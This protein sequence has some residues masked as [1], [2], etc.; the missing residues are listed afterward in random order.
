MSIIRVLAVC[1][2]VACGLGACTQDPLEP[3]TERAG[4]LATDEEVRPLAASAVVVPTAE[5]HQAALSGNPETMADAAAALV[6]CPAPT[7]CPGYSN[8]SAWSAYADCNATCGF[9]LCDPLGPATNSIIRDHTLT[10]RAKSYRICTNSMGQSC[11][12][13]KVATASTCGC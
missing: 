10:E 11:T 5:L 2:I 8:C 13:W 7:T 9:P 3:S 6:G 4:M 12:E 1:L